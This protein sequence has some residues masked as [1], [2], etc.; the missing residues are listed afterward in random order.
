MT[1]IE[2]ANSVI[3]D[4]QQQKYSN[5][6]KTI[7]MLLNNNAELGDNWGG[8]TR[9]ALSIGQVKMAIKASKRYL[10]V[11]PNEKKRVIQCAG[12]FAECREVSAGI[13]LVKPL[14]DKENTPDVLHFL[15]TAYSQIG[16]F[17]LAKKYLTSL[18]KD[19]PQIAISWLT[20][21]AIHTFTAEDELYK[22]LISSK[23]LF[24]DKKRSHNAPFW[25]ALG[26]AQLDVKN[27]NEAFNNF[28]HGCKLVHNEV[29]YNAKHHSKFIDQIIQNQNK[30]NI[31]TL[32]V[33]NKVN[34][35]SPIFI[36]GLPRSGTT[37]LQQILSAH[38]HVGQGGELK[39]LG[40][41][42][43]EIGQKTLNKLTCQPVDF[44]LST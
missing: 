3:K 13:S 41:S 17:D 33:L 34:F 25:F 24:V 31:A 5:A 26:K 22:K 4:V 18:I 35:P 37:L 16:E 9:L 6:A 21:A 2:L 19:V 28:Y 39:Y 43:A 11:A 20:L 30:N 29:T 7:L 42:S 27:E 40:F 14:I 36:V 38:S 44:Q 23:Q 8:I 15:G 1:D 32:P 12:I 10:A